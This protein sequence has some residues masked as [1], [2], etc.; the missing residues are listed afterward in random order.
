MAATAGSEAQAVSMMAPQPG[1]WVQ[2]AFVQEALD[3]FVVLLDDADFAESFRIMGLGWRHF[4]RRRQM[5]VE[6]QG[7]Y[8]ALWRLALQRSFPEDADRMLAAF[9]QDYRQ[10]HPD[11]DTAAALDRAVPYWDMLRVRGESDFTGVARHLCS[12]FSLDERAERSMVLRLVLH[13]RK[14]YTEIFR[15]LI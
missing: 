12:F 6:W 15:R 2:G 14:R 3:N 1:P 11:K 10:Q 13:I 7:L 8:V 5:R 9:C 4:M